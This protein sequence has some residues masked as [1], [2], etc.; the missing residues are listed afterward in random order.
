MSG[1]GN[2]SCD[3]SAVLVVSNGCKL[4]AYGNRLAYFNALKLYRIYYSVIK[5]QNLY[6][7]VDSE[8]A[9]RLSECKGKSVFAHF[10]IIAKVKKIIFSLSGKLGYTRS[11][12]IYGASATNAAKSEIGIFG[13]GNLL[14][15]E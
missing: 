5:T 15:R 1:A 14:N 11:V 7:R 4:Y 12:H 2:K 6:G 13:L 9:L 8:V 10:D 3:T